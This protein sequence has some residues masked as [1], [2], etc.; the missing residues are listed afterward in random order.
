LSL[1]NGEYFCEEE[2]F[3]FK[4]YPSSKIFLS[5]LR[6]QTAKLKSKTSLAHQNKKFV[7]FECHVHSQNR[8]KVCNLSSGMYKKIEISCSNNE[9][10]KFLYIHTQ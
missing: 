4:T 1:I 7:K 6:F 2:V 5:L 3:A 8:K 9:P 10:Q